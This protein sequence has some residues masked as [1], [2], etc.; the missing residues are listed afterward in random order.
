ML[1]KIRLLTRGIVN[2]RVCTNLKRYHPLVILCNLIGKQPAIPYLCYT[3][4]LANI[5]RAEQ[6][7]TNPLIKF[8]GIRNTEFIR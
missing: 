7:D 1:S 5:L 3:R 2:C 6:L 4:P 8:C